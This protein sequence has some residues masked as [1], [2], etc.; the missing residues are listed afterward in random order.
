MEAAPIRQ[1]VG[2]ESGRSP[3]EFKLSSAIFRYL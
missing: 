1:T 2:G 3:L